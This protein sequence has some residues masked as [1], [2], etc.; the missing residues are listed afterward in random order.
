M[1]TR[2]VKDS[3]VN[4]SLNYSL[5]A[6]L[7]RYSVADL[8]ADWLLTGYCETERLCSEVSASVIR[9]VK[10]SASKVSAIG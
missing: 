6:D 7:A 8:V 9:L 3:A 4:D 2:L 10:V 5:V 1:K